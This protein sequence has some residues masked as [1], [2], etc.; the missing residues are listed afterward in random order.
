M[1][2][3]ARER[4][5]NLYF[6]VAKVRPYH[7]EIGIKCEKKNFNCHLIISLHSQCDCYKCL[8]RLLSQYPVKND[9]TCRTYIQNRNDISGEIKFL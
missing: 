3:K 6:A 1:E 4:L 8:H 7:E 9:L 5:N 2:L